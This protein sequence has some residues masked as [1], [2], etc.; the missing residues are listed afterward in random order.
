MSKEGRV[1]EFLK[2]QPPEPPSPPE[3]LK[4][5]DI[6][7][8]VPPFYKSI[9]FPLLGED[10]APLSLVIDRELSREQRDLVE[11]LI[12]ERK[13]FKNLD[14]RDVLILDSLTLMINSG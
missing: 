7:E 4:T 9:F 10:L 3:F 12:S 13:R 14:S 2:I 5:E 6:K 11:D 8:E 1:F